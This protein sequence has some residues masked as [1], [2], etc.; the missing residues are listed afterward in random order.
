MTA[1]DH[2]DTV[3][4]PEKGAGVSNASLRV[5][6]TQARYHRSHDGEDPTKKRQSP[7]VEVSLL[8]SD[9]LLASLALGGVALGSAAS[10]SRL[11]EL[12]GL[13]LVP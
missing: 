1:V 2:V 5:D 7:P 10:R 9:V 4:A 3:A 11:T 12:L 8:E 6:T 13:L